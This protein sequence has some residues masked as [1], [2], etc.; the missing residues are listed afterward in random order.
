M[1]AG[2]GRSSDAYPI[3]G[4]VFPK[5]EQ[6]EELTWLT[7]TLGEVESALSLPPGRI[8]LALLI[9]SGWAVAQLPQLAQLAAPRLCA[10]ILGLADYAADLGLPQIANVHPLADWARAQVID[11][12]GA[13]GVPA[14]DGMTLD[15][16]VT[17][18]SLSQS[19]NRERFLSRMELVYQEALRARAMGMAGKWVGHPA[20]LFA[21]LLAFELEQAGDG[22]EQLARQ[23][24][25]YE[26][27]VR[28]REQGV[29]II[30]GVMSD[31]AT[32]RHARVLLRRAVAMGRLHPLR[33]LELG[34]IAP[35]E[36]A[37]A[38]ALAQQ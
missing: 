22:L 28:S 19:A 38:Q 1:S 20:Q 18:S 23:L 34:V 9:E 26:E 30:E 6:P 21:V 11:V 24:G 3:D 8:R 14:I 12:A 16:P 27:A 35:D 31:R 7:E 2:R 25:V 5:I 13:V 32:D 29:S 10:L 4:I 33:A 17:D 36:L 37:V 15:F